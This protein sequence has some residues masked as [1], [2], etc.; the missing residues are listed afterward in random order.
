MK[1]KTY[2]KHLTKFRRQKRYW[3]VLLASVMI[4]S[5]VIGIVDKQWAVADYNASEGQKPSLINEIEVYPPILSPVK[6]Y[7][8]IEAY[9]A[10]LN[11]DEVER[12]IDCECPSW[13]KYCIGDQGKS[14]GLWQIHKG[15]HPEV[16]NECAFSEVCST[17]WAIEKRIHDGNWKSWTCGRNL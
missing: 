2:Q 4:A 7:V 8:L 15:Y 17:K 3:Y 11:P 9:K 6:Q 5:A 10:G 16:S 14:R 1:N 12:I 13:D